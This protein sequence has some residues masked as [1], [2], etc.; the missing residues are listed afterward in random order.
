MQ[1]LP[2]VSFGLVGCS[3]IVIDFSVTWLLK[4]KANLNKYIASSAGFCMAVVTNYLLNKQFTF[5]NSVGQPATQFIKFAAVSIAGLLLSN[6][7][8]WLLQKKTSFNFYI[9]KMLV[10]GIVFFWNYTANAFFTF[11]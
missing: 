3:G 4:E 2:I 7:L 1:L 8:L 9:S 6:V 5:H 11:K 10:I